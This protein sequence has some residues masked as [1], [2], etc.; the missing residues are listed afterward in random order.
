MSE[1]LLYIGL[2]AL[3]AP[4]TIIS[5]M[6]E[7]STPQS[8]TY[9]SLYAGSIAFALTLVAY[10]LITWYLGKGMIKHPKYYV[11][12]ISLYLVY[13]IAIA[14]ASYKYFITDDRIGAK[15]DGGNILKAN[16]Y[17]KLRNSLRAQIVTYIILLLGFPVILKIFKPHKYDKLVSSYLS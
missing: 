9:I 12:V 8:S 15:T 11:G 16:A 2:L 3:I 17:I 7:I 5:Q 14:I 10:P 13:N 1:L 4:G 6:A